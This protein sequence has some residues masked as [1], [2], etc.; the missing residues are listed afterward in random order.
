MNENKK[1]NDSAFV[2]TLL[3]ILVVYMISLILPMLWALYTS[4][5]GVVD[6]QVDSIFPT[7]P[8]NFEPYV[9]AFEN[10]VMLVDEDVCVAAVSET[11]MTVFK[12]NS[13]V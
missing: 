7:F 11:K 5:K 10:F 2:I 6:F 8:F 9:T 1:N 4:F 3:V 13:K 12:N